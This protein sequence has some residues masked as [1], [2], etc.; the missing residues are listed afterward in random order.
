[1]LVSEMA[2]ITFKDGK[3]TLLETGPGVTVDQVVA[4]TAA[5]LSLPAN[6]PEMPL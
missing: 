1:M 4:A 3:A 2:V 5:R 6:I